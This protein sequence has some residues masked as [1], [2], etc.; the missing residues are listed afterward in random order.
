MGGG[1]WQINEILRG[2][3]CQHLSAPQMLSSRLAPVT[4]QCPDASIQHEK[5]KGADAFH[6][7]PR[8]VQV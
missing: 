1:T 3:A 5:G 2:G 6:T 7:K 8:T 4:R